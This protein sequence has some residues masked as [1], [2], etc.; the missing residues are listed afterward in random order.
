MAL[1]FFEDPIAPESQ[2]EL[3]RRVGPRNYLCNKGNLGEIWLRNI[4]PSASYKLGIYD[5][6]DKLLTTIDSEMQIDSYEM[7][8]IDIPEIDQL[9][10]GNNSIELRVLEIGGTPVTEPYDLSSSSF[11]IEYFNTGLEGIIEDDFDGAS[12]YRWI[13]ERQ[14]Y[15]QDWIADAESG[16]SLY[17]AYNVINLF[18]KLGYAN[19]LWSP[20]VNVNEMDK[21]EL[22]IDYAFTYLEV[23]QGNEVFSLSDTLEIQYSIDCGENWNTFYKASGADLNTYGPLSDLSTFFN[24]PPNGGYRS[25]QLDLSD[26]DSETAQF[27]LNYISGGLGIFW[28]DKITIGDINGS[29]ADIPGLKLYPNPATD[30]VSVTSPVNLTDLELID[31][32]GK[33]LRTIGSGTELNL[34]IQSLPAGM[35]IIKGQAEGQEFVKTFIKQ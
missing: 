1:E 26:I 22:T 31:A 3:L 21:K 27:K 7:H 9:V 33:S 35:Y 14:F 23:Q 29:V 10:E 15:N 2:I 34:D 28:L 32:S 12:D 16:R 19:T 18:D 20:I 11:E 6:S 17:V 24:Y 5:G 30:A 13:N 8:K 4:G 25:L